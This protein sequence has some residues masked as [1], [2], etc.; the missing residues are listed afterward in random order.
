[1]SRVSINISHFIIVLNMERFVAHDFCSEKLWSLVYYMSID[2]YEFS[3]D[4]EIFLLLNGI[5][6]KYKC[7]WKYLFS[8]N[9]MWTVGGDKT[10]GFNQIPFLW[11]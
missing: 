4:D 1:M 6:P 8:G 7:L 9:K 3:V 10:V 2:S 5:K 11:F